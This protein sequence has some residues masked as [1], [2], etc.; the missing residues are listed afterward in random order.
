MKNKY[1]ILVLLVALAASVSF[2]F[3]QEN[4]PLQIHGS[5]LQG[6]PIV[7]SYLP[8]A[9]AAWATGEFRGQRLRFDALG[10]RLIS[11]AAIDRNLRSGSYTLKLEV[12]YA[13]GSRARFDFEIEVGGKKFPT[14]KLNVDPKF[15]S[16]S[17]KNLAWARED[18]KAAA[19]AYAKSDDVRLWHA[20]FIIPVEGRK[21]SEF[22]VR[23]MFNGEERSYHSGSDIA[24]PT[25]T[26]IVAT[27]SGKVALVKSMFFGGNTVLID[28]GQGVFSGYMHLSEFAVVQDEIVERGQL[29]GLAGATGRVTGPHLHWMLRVHGVK[30][31]GLGILDFQ[32]LK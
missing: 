30:V 32:P 2:T 9:A 8:E 12:T 13:D 17:K 3:A 6:E 18:N 22:G 24:V 26:P 25:G 29:L 15:V 10:D 28:H 11:V 4:S 27:N 14:S 20:E 1:Y 16:L 31:N 19:A 21:S 7:I 23:R 5:A